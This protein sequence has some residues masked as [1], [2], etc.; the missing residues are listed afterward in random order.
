M[1]IF[2]VS[3]KLLLILLPVFVWKL[4]HHLNLYKLH[5]AKTSLIDLLGML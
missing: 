3:Y 5:T 2:L 4:F 1:T